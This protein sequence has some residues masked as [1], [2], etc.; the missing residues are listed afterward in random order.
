[1]KKYL[2]V[3]VIIILLPVLVSCEKNGDERINNDTDL[4]LYNF[5]HANIITD[6]GIKKKT[7]LR[8]NSCYFYDSHL[9][10]ST[11]DAD[12][13]KGEIKNNDFYANLSMSFETGDFD[14]KINLYQI[15]RFDLSFLCSIYCSRY[16]IETN[17]NVL[18]DG[19]NVYFSV[20]N[21]TDDKSNFFYQ[22][23]M[24]YD[25]LNFTFQT[26]RP[27]YECIQLVH[28]QTPFYG[29]FDKAMYIMYNNMTFDERGLK[30]NKYMNNLYKDNEIINGYA[31]DYTTKQLIPMIET[32]E[33]DKEN[34]QYTNIRTTRSNGT[35]TV[36][37]YSKVDSD[38]KF[39]EITRKILSNNKSQ[40]NGE[41]ESI[42]KFTNYHGDGF[43]LYIIDA[44]DVDTNY[45]QIEHFKQIDD[46]DLEFQSIK[47]EV[48][49]EEKY[50]TEY[51]TITR[52]PSGVYLYKKDL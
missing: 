52:F 4:F 16:K 15:K 30:S 44:F 29:L 48:I 22:T 51:E 26:D 3:L 1:M 46:F 14:R 25:D 21:D 38:Y 7:F 33:I 34:D 42:H 47:Y 37:L 43:F 12:E 23:L 24:K 11:V 49:E 8:D 20:H 50:L 18:Y 13:I 10:S 31:T 6:E 41:R 36:E 45:M 28:D 27:F 32:F 39:I 5:F 35:Q 9:F 40:I 17:I 2:F 19:Q